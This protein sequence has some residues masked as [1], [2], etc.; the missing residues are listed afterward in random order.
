[1]NMGRRDGVSSEDVLTLLAQ[2]AIPREDILHVNVRHHHTFV[3]VRRPSFQMVLGALDGAKI[4][5]RVARAEQA[6]S[7]RE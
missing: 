1:M 7:A 5:G 2:S 4:A 6:R 3:G